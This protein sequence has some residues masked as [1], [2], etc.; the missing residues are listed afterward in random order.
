M[1]K[2]SRVRVS[3]TALL[4]MALATYVRPSVTKQYNL[5][6][7]RHQDFHPG[8][9]TNM[10]TKAGI[11]N[12]EMTNLYTRLPIKWHGHFNAKRRLSPSKRSRRN[13]QIFLHARA[14]ERT[15]PRFGDANYLVLV[16]GRWYSKTR[17][18]G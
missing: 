5:V 18:V 1:I 13:S 8:G 17:K 11:H 6:Q 9:T 15:C 12:K 4:S 3:H 7:W 10:F 16:A 14:P 2:R